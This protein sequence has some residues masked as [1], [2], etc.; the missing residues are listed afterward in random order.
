MNR[1][2]A[3]V[4]K[5]PVLL[6]L[7][8]EILFGTII[9]SMTFLI[10]WKLADTVLDKER[11][12][13]D[14]SISLF[15]YG[16]RTPLLTA[17][18][19]FFSFIGMDGILLFS[20]VLPIFFYWKKRKHESILFTIM[21]GMG[22]I[23]NI[24]LKLITQR[25]RPTFAPLVIEHTYSFPSGHSMNSFIFFITIS[26]FFY[27]FSHKK[28]KSLFA[29]CIAIIVILCIGASRIY[30]GVHYPSDVLG[31]YITGF[32]W[33]LCILLIDKTITFYKVFKIQ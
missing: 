28:K 30:L 33:F 12:A 9:S 4:R 13:F 29:F 10:F 21:V 14:T 11:F 23:L 18:M 27:H 8:L 7:S 5:T 26:Y 22:A 20:I 6:V 17:V 31:G 19:Q 1:F 2:L 16:L 15:F 32:L 24:V 3:H 25:P